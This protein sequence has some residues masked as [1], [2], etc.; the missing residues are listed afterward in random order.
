[1]LSI[2]KECVEGLSKKCKLNNK[3]KFTF[4]EKLQ[5]FSEILKKTKKDDSEIVKLLIQYSLSLLKQM[6][7]NIT[8]EF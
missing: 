5:S 1:M 4:L 8:F 6:K 2:V 3:E 7:P